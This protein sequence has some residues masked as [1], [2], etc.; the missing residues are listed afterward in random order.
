L[1]EAY[2][3]ADDRDALVAALKREHVDTASVEGLA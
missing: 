3:K 2:R 1:R